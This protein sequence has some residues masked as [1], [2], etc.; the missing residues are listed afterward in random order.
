MRRVDEGI[1]SAHGAV[2]TCGLVCTQG[3]ALGAALIYQLTLPYRFEH[4][5]DPRVGVKA[6]FNVA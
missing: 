6:F 5:R 4:R 1:L 2:P 3:L